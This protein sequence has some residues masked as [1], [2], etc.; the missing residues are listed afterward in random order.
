MS[1]FVIEGGYPIQGAIRPIGNKNAALPLLAAC[2][3]TD[4]PVTLHNVPNIGDVETMIAILQQLGVEVSRQERSVTLCARHANRTD[5][6]PT[7]FAQIRGSLTL[8]G[9]L[10]ARH[11][12]FSVRTNAGGDDI[13]RRRIDTHL[14]VLEGLGA[15]M[16][17]NG[18]FSLRSRDRL[19]GAD[20]L[21]D[22]TSVTATENGLMAAALA[23]GATILRNAASEPHVQDL[24]RLLMTMGCPIE[25]VGSNTLTIH[26]QESLRGGEIYISP[27]FVEVGSFIG[28]GAITPGELRIEGVAPDHLRMINMVF[29]QRFGVR[30]RLEHDPAAPPELAYTLVV[31]PKQELRVRP[32]FGG[33]VPKLDDGPWPHFPPDLMSIA[34][35][36]ATQAQGT[37]IIHEKMYESR[38]YFVDKLTTM[39]AQ[40]ILCDPHRAVVVGPSRLV[41][42]PVSS[43]DIR[44][45][46]ALVLA[47]LVADGV[48]TIGNVQQ[49]D[50]GYER[51]DE[52]LRSLGARIQRVN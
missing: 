18:K 45:G 11:R 50:R 28:L 14:Q 4:E 44:A 42:Q 6:D 15:T 52:K 9:P 48:T 30:M 32:D 16:D 23:R 47:A 3:L 46:M 19:C 40:I 27:D 21:L 36:V 37:I 26:G 22:E 17:T 10:L 20:I 43:P 24:C 51:I 35:V 8:M 25:G 38:L 39:G 5:P 2:L 1:S 13:G 7:L 34:L 29:G 49:I 12:H 41:G 31:E 33:A